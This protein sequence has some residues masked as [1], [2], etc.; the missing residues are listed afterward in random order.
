MNF[1]CTY[2]QRIQSRWRVGYMNVPCTSVFDTYL[3]RVDLT[4][5]NKFDI[6]LKYTCSIHIRRVQVAKFKIFSNEN[7]VRFIILEEYFGGN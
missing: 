7:C 1:R 5:N 2:T 4:G 3:V 6:W